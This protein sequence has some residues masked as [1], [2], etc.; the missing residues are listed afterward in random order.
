M[1]VEKQNHPCKAF[2]GGEMMKLSTQLFT[3]ERN[4]QIKQQ[5]QR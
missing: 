1:R 4:T 3:S 2:Y 5:R